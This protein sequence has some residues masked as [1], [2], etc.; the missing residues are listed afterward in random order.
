YSLR[1][2]AL[3]REIVRSVPG[4]ASLAPGAVELFDYLKEHGIP[5]VIASASIIQNIEF[6]VETFHLDRWFDMGHIVYD[7]NSYKNKE[8]MFREALRRIGA[9]ENVLI[10]EDSLSGISGA[11]NVGAS[12]VA[13]RKESL[14]SFYEK[15][16]QIIDVVE[17]FREAE[18]YFEEDR[19]TSLQTI[20]VKD[21]RSTSPQSTD[22]L[23]NMPTL[24]SSDVVED[25][26]TI[27]VVAAVIRDGDRIY[28]TQRG[29]GEY[30]DGWEFPGGKIEPGE[31]PE[32]ALVREI[33]EE[34]AVTIEV[35][36]K[37]STIEYD[38][39]KFHLSMD[40]FWC[41]IVDGEIHLQEHEAARWLTKE[42]LAA[43]DWLPAD[44]RLIAEMRCLAT[45]D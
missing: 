2:E 15:I 43:V 34:L 27:R 40:C 24:S 29:Y 41:R 11:A 16:P 28:A 39:P 14:E 4:G 26:P 10:F 5:C 13:I 19:L 17:D 30:K 42:D 38:Y 7:D 33:R 45:V 25:K 3:Y 21:D 20:D 36:E 9:D 37:I 44:R 6:F 12:V 31:T 32:E 22:A 35:G 8:M 1:K 18:R 23:E